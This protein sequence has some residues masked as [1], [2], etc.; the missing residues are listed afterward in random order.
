MTTVLPTA[1]S[2]T[3]ATVARVP[4][5]KTGPSPAAL[6]VLEVRKSLSTRSG[7]AVA[8]A[9]VVLGP[10]IMAVL[11]GAEQSD[12]PAAAIGEFGLFAV[13]VLAALGVLSTAGEWTHRTVQTTFLV[14]PQ[15]GRVLAAKAAAMAL[16][17]AGLAAASA[18]ASALVLA[19]VADGADWDGALRAVVVV[20]AAG[21]AFAVIGAGIGAVVG[22]SAAA[23]TGTYLAFLVVFPLLRSVQPE[24]AARSDPT[25]AVLTLTAGGAAT[26][27]VLVLVGW[28][29]LATGA[30]VLVTRRR[31]V[32]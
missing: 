28:T 13:L 20:A 24:L 11:A 30:G 2:S 18:G 9:A 1:P 26:T 3:S 25:D 16:L 8:I 23:L 29:V 27:P 21:A 15:R 12:A 10:V 4:V 14:V 6:V 5:R 7:R 32:A 31:A 19:A 22:N 17:G